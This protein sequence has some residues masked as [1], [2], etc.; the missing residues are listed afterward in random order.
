MSRTTI[1]SQTAW[2]ELEA[3]NTIKSAYTLSESDMKMIEDKFPELVEKIEDIIAEHTTSKLDFEGMTKMISPFFATV[4]KESEYFD[5]R[6]SYG[7]AAAALELVVASID[8]VSKEYHNEIIPQNKVI[9]HKDGS[10][11]NHSYSWHRNYFAC[12]GEAFDDVQAFLDGGPMPKGFHPDCGEIGSGSIALKNGKKVNVSGK[13]KSFLRQLGSVRVTMRGFDEKELMDYFKSTKAYKKQLGM[14]STPQEVT[15]SFRRLVKFVNKMSTLSFYKTYK[16]Q[17]S[18]RT[19][20]LNGIQNIGLHT[21]GKHIYRFAVS[22]RVT[23]SDKSVAKFNLAQIWSKKIKGRTLSFKQAMK[24]FKRNSVAIIAYFRTNTSLSFIEKTYW[25]DVISQIIMSLPGGRTNVPLHWD[26]TASGPMTMAASFR[27]SELAHFVNLDGNKIARDFHQTV[28]DRFDH[29]ETRDDIKAMV[30]NPLWHGSSLYTPALATE[31]EPG[32]FINEMKEEYGAVAEYP[33][34][35]GEM[36]ALLVNEK[37]SFYQFK[38]GNGFMAHGACYF[39]GGM[40]SLPYPSIQKGNMKDI[41]IYGDEPIHYNDKFRAVNTKKNVDIHGDS[42]SK[43][44]SGTKNRSLLA[45][46]LHSVEWDLKYELYD[47]MTE[48]MFDVH[49][50]YFSTGRGLFQ[51]LKIMG[52]FNLKV[53]DEQPVQRALVDALDR[54]R[55]TYRIEGRKFV[56]NADSIEFM[57]PSGKLSRKKVSASVAY[58]QP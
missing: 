12:K 34:M 25:E 39:E 16:F 20:H 27:S 32:D 29:I 13:F 7:V 50:D 24:S 44:H 48:P 40:T 4:G 2:A 3:I 53:Y 58:L 54:G 37:K 23:R 36:T 33:S 46:I 56:S 21:G 14:A 11:E 15:K 43:A 6:R 1:M 19:Q 22:R 38:T 51:V 18:G 47:Q 55:V 26:R 45:A 49:D 31:M 41:T 42:T 17:P 5:K 28:L 9:R 8:D 52:A 10:V 57:F 30:Q 35:I